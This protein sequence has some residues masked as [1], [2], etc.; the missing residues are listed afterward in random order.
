VF[1]FCRVPVDPFLNDLRDGVSRVAR[2]RSV[3]WLGSSVCASELS[4]HAVA[5]GSCEELK[6]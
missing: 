3:G 4:V 2:G 6:L 5:V 1:Y